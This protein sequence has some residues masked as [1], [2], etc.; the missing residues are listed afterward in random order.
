MTSGE[1]SRTAGKRGRLRTFGQQVQS[2]DRSLP[3]GGAGGCRPTSSLPGAPSAAPRPRFGPGEAAR[4]HLTPLRQNLASARAPPG[5]PPRAGPP[6]PRRRGRAGPAASSPAAPRHRLP[7]PGPLTCTCLRKWRGPGAAHGQ[8]QQQQQRRRRRR[9]RHLA[10]RAAPGAGSRVAL[11]P[12]RRSV[13]RSVLPPSAASAAPAPAALGHASLRPHL[14]PAP[15]PR[16]PLRPRKHHPSR[17]PACPRRRLSAAATAAALQSRGPRRPRSHRHDGLRH[18][19]W[20]GG[21]G[22]TP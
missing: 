10:R 2:R 5:L 4:P 6:L 13:P 8:E 19:T 20:G 1:G 17:P 3:R 22:G 21:G 9:P 16:P 15:G 12:V 18:V 11:P 14:S 7:A